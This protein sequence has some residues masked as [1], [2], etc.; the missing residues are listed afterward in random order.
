MNVNFI[1]GL[2]LKEIN[3]NYCRSFQNNN[4]KK[5]MILLSRKFWCDLSCN[6]FM[7]ALKVCC[8]GAPVDFWYGSYPNICGVSYHKSCSMLSI[9]IQECWLP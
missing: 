2:V 4:K 6:F 5:N 8:T 7:L 9:N 3:N 1:K